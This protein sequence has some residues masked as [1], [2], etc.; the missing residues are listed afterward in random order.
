MNGDFV[1]ESLSQCPLTMKYTL[2]KALGNLGGTKSPGKK[3][4]STDSPIKEAKM[5]SVKKDIQDKKNKGEDKNYA[6]LHGYTPK[7]II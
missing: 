4:K 7:A 3:R 2:G 1:S 6:I 5:T